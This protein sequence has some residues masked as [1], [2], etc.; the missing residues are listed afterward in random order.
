M[1]GPEGT[2]GFVDHLFAGGAFDADIR[3]RA[4]YAKRQENYHVLTP[5]VRNLSP[6]PVFEDENVKVTAA[7]AEHIPRDISACFALRFE[8]DDKAV[9]FS[10]D[11]SPCAA[12]E[13]LACG[14]DLLVH[15]CTFPRTALE[16]RDRVGVGT[17]AHTSPLALGEIATRAQVKSLIATHF[18]HFDASNPILRKIMA[19]HMPADQIGPELLDEMV[20]DIRQNYAGPLQL[21]RDLMRIEI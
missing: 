21:A 12:V 8:T 1:L 4:A 14:A 16:F 18:G 19:L 2:Q 13:Q 15:D 10:S 3:A 5:E 6:G 17:S 9:V 20:A 11:T 7:Y